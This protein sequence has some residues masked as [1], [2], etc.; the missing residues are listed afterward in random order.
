MWAYPRRGRPVN[1]RVVAVAIVDDEDYESIV[2]LSPWRLCSY[3]RKGKAPPRY[4]IRGTP[5]NQVSMHRVIL[6]AQRGQ[7]VDHRDGD[8]L[9][10]RRTNLR[11]ATR[12]QNQRNKSATHTN[13]SGY[14]GVSLFTTPGMWATGKWYA[15]IKLNRQTIHLGYFA[16]AEQAARA[17]DCAA[18]LYHGEFARLNFPE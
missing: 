2:A 15:R 17:Y 9:N 10:N 18:R 12:A 6:G 5:P 1:G 3:K 8:G 7:E 4:A 14:K 11:L 16:T 13:R